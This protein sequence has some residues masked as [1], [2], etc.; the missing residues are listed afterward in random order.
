MQVIKFIFLYLALMHSSQAQT[1]FS[2]SDLSW[3]DSPAQTEEKLKKSGLRFTSI[4]SII[5]C[6]MQDQCSIRFGNNVR[7]EMDFVNGKLVFVWIFE[8]DPRQ[9]DERLR[10]LVATYGSPKHCSFFPK[11]FN[12]IRTEDP[13]DVCW[14]TK[15]GETLQIISGGSIKYTSKER[16]FPPMKSS[17]GIKF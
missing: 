8:D 1:N 7:G 9:Y 16:N 6:K 2:F 10:K 5:V 4:A 17:E 14:A 11:S 15:E 13:R 3:G 12:L